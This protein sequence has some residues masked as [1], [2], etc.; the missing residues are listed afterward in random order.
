MSGKQAQPGEMRD[1]FC[2]LCIA[3][4]EIWSDMGGA[5]GAV[6]DAVGR[7]LTALDRCSLVITPART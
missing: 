6:L 1:M 3:H 4:C 7:Q 5:L 2:V